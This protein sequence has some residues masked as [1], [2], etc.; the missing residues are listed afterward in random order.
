LQFWDF[1]RKN[2]DEDWS[3]LKWIVWD[4]FEFDKASCVCGYSFHDPC[5]F[6]AR[7]YYASLCCDMYNSSTHYVSSCPYYACY[8]QSNSSLPLT[9]CTGLKVGEPF[10]LVARI[11]M[12]NVGCGLENSFEE[13]HNLVDI[14]S[15]G[16]PNMFVHERSPNLGSNHVIPNSLDHFHVPTMRSQ[17]S[18]S[19]PE[20]DYNVPIGNFVICDSNINL[21]LE[22]NVLN[23]LGGNYENFESL[24][25]FSGYDAALDPY[26]INLV[27]EPRKILW[28]TFFVFSFDF[29]MV[30]SLIKRALTFFSLILCMLSYCYACDPT[31]WSSTNFYVP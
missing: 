23:M 15:E 7:S 6:Y 25:Y 5:A 31:S 27:N 2:V 26:C 4:S 30:F 8:T 3:L 12:N 9:W 16:C 11:G 21:G 18:S 14:P 10:G 20:L 29:A 24:G 1:H 19:S 17:P 13:V 28:N 22:N